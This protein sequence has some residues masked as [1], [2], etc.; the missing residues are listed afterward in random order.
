MGATLRAG[1]S[2]PA[3][4]VDG[5]GRHG[6]ISARGVGQGVGD[7]AFYYGSPMTQLAKGH[8]AIVKKIALSQRVR[9]LQGDIGVGTGTK[10]NDATSA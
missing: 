9:Y 2:E 6:T 7:Q 3:F 5:L 4:E 8:A 10:E 1:R